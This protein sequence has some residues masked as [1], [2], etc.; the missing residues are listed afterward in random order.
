MITKLRVVTKQITVIKLGGSILRTPQDFEEILRK[1]TKQFKEDRLVLVV[2]AVKGVTDS[3]IAMCENAGSKDHL[4][5]IIAPYYN[6]IEHLDLHDE[7]L[8]GLRKLEQEFIYILQR[9]YNSPLYKDRALSFGERASALIVHSWL[10]H[11]GYSSKLLGPN[12]IGLITTSEYGNAEPI[13]PQVFDNIKQSLEHLIER[14]VIPVIPGF[15][16]I[17]IEGNI[18]TMGRGASDLTA[19]LTAKAL[20]ADYLYLVTET[21]G[22]MSADPKIVPEAKIVPLIDFDE[23]K[24]AA[25]YKVKNLH[26]RTFNYVDDFRGLIKIV[27]KNFIGTTIS[28]SYA[29][30]ITKIVTNY[31]TSVVMIG[32]GTNKIAENVLNELNLNRMHIIDLSEVH[33]ILNTPWDVHDAIRKIHRVI[34]R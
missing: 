22:I 5:A 21:P 24:I 7:A 14:G 29:P 33:A 3:I 28:N 15:I 20:N 27:N 31:N 32:R 18:T 6:A 19:T 17:D 12:D 16:G 13:V 26:K 34:L 1:I 30:S 2:S 8:D 10:K 9:C 11:E 23:A 4:E 25:E